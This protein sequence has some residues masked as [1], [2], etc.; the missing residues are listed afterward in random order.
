MYL[1]GRA[2]LRVDSAIDEDSGVYTIICENEIGEA[3]AQVT[4]IVK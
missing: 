2:S 3:R 4:V 1:D